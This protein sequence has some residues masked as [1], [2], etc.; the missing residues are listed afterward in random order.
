M[1][2]HIL[3]MFCINAARRIRTG[4]RDELLNLTDREPADPYAHLE[5]SLVLVPKCSRNEAHSNKTVFEAY[6]RNIN[7]TCLNKNAPHYDECSSSFRPLEAAFKPFWFTQSSHA[8]VS[9]FRTLPYET[10]DVRAFKYGI[11]QLFG[12]TPGNCS[13]VSVGSKKV[14]QIVHQ[15]GG[16]H[17]TDSSRQMKFHSL[18]VHELAVQTDGAGR[19]GTL[20]SSIS[21]AMYA[22]DGKCVHL[23]CSGPEWVCR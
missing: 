7:I 10:D 4:S 9:E 21:R 11:A 6:L 8:I 16:F 1:H 3:C 13:S 2:A 18:R 15:D 20:I 14:V 23:L 5:G 17:G 12:M 19:Q 22:L